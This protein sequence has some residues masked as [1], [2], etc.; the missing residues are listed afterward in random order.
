[1]PL[2]AQQNSIVII[3]IIEGDLWGVVG[4]QWGFVPA[5][6]FLRKR[7]LRVNGHRF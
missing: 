7:S 4:E 1:M 2:P 5:K 6:G 3:I